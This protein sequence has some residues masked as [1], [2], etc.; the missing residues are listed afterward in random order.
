MPERR[1][2]KATMQTLKMI[3]AKKIIDQYDILL[4]DAYGVIVH[5]SGPLG[6]AAQFI[7][8]LNASG[9]P[10]YIVTNDASKLP[11]SASEKYQ[12]YGL[13]LSPERIITSGMLL[14]NHFKSHS[15][16]GVPCVVFGPA[17]S[18]RYV[19]LAGGI[20]VSPE[21]PFTVLVVADEA[22][23]PFLDTLDRVLSGLFR[24]IDSGRDVTML[25]PNP[26]LIYPKNEKEFGITSGSIALILESAIH[27]RYPHHPH[28]NFV[29]LGKPNAAI[30]QEARNRAGGGRMVMVG[31]QLETDIRG[32]N[33]FG[34][35]SVLIHGG[36]T[37]HE[38]SI[39]SDD[40]RPTY[41]MKSLLFPC[42]C[43]RG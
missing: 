8:L 34:I 25:L 22:G 6:G 24:M 38:L 18:R 36:V 28:L 2:H 3:T 37:S 39:Y 17:D 26:D 27:L 21:A 4:L 5:S 10:Y 14:A 31:D 12:N 42:T 20:V 7:D 23:A 16:A 15:L 1:Q 9:K 19:E 29:P 40:L 41:I 43:S 13:A 32:A 33:R 30:F 35:D 11:E